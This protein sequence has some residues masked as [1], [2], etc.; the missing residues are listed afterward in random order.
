MK[1]LWKASPFVRCLFAAEAGGSR[2]AGEDS[3]IHL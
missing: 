2:Q 1:I 3:A